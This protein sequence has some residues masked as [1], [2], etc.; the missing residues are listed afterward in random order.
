MHEK[1]INQDH[2]YWPCNLT[3][4]CHR[5]KRTK[6]TDEG[7]SSCP[8]ALESCRLDKMPH[9]RAAV[10]EALF[11]AKLLA[12]GD[13]TQ[14]CSKLTDTLSKSICKSVEQSHS[15]W[16]KGDIKQGPSPWTKGDISSSPVLQ[17]RIVSPT[18]QESNQLSFSPASTSTME[19][20]HIRHIS[21][22]A[23]RN[24]SRSSK[25]TPLYPARGMGFTQS[26]GCNSPGA[27]SPSGSSLD[28]CDFTPQKCAYTLA[29][30]STS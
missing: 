10:S 15:S 24:N 12:S 20:M 13:S 16:T 22:P 29:I 8:Q 11:V 3:R 25:R 2:Q 18:S 17:T 23:K 6:Y 7:V 30:L 4:A 26:P 9:V 28:E 21:T 1:S 19:S 14:S 27:F 5:N